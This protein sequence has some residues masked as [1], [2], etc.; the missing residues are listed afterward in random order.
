MIDSQIA[1]S[2]TVEAEEFDLYEVPEPPIAMCFHL[3]EFLAAT[4]LAEALSLQ[5][6]LSFSDADAPLSITIESDSHESFFVLA[7]RRPPESAMASDPAGANAKKRTHEEERA[8][9]PRKKAMTVVKAEPRRRD[10]PSLRTGS[11]SNASQASEP[12]FRVPDPPRTSQTP[13]PGPSQAHQQSNASSSRAASSTQQRPAAR[14]LFYPISP[15]ASQRQVERFDQLSQADQ[16]VIRASGLGI[17]DMSA[18]ELA[19]MLNDDD[20]DMEDVVQ[21]V[22]QASW[23]AATRTVSQAED[24][25]SSGQATGSA[26]DAMMVIDDD[27]EVEEED[28]WEEE[29]SFIPMTQMDARVGRRRDKSNKQHFEV[30]DFGDD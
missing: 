13:V 2:I 1:T 10:S 29:S 12:V 26:T 14:P 8:S 27:E 7:V 15:S 23:H 5:L 22:P 17:E 19:A 18:D 9:A 24:R 25:H 28:N 11:N 20:E 3:R 4:A 16:E 30:L 21:P 6:N